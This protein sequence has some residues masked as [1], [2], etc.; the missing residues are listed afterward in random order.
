MFKV[1]NKTLFS[2]VSIVYI[3]DL[4][5]VN[6]SWV[7]ESCLRV[8]IIVML[9]LHFNDTCSTVLSLM[10]HSTVLR[11]EYIKENLEYFMRPTSGQ[12]ICSK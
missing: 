2:S 5:Q 6:V 7:L 1:N 8:I 10:L 4:E 12:F 11:N 9:L 3:V